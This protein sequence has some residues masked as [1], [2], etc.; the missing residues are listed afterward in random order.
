MKTFLFFTLL[1]FSFSL[2]ASHIVGGDI[3]YDYLGGNNYR[4]YITIYRDCASTGAAF[5]DPLPLAVYTNGSSSPI[6]QISVPFPG[7]VILPVTFNNPCGTAPGGV[8]IEKAV[9]IAVISLPPIQGGYTITYQRCCRGPAISNLSSPDNTGLTLTTNVPGSETGATQNSSPRF[10]N[11]PPLLLCNNDELIFDHSATDPDGDQLVYSLVI[12]FSGADAVTP[13][14]IPAPPPPYFPVTWAT[15]YTTTTPL[16]ASSPISINSSTGLLTATPNA[17]GLFVVGIRVQEYRNGVLIGQTIRDFLFRV[18]NCNITLSAQLPIQEDLASFVSYCQGLTVNFENNSYGGTVY[19][20][21]FGVNGIST[22]VSSTF[23]PSY[24]YPAPG[25]YQATLVVNPGEPCTDTARMTVTVNNEFS[26]SFTTQDSVCIVGNSLDFVSQTVGGAASSYAWD[27]GPNA[28]TSSAST[29]NVNN[30]SFNTSGFIPI[31]L[32]A[33]NSSCTATFTDSIYIFSEPT[34]SIILP[35]GYEC[36]GLTVS[37]GNNSSNAAIYQWDFGVTNSTM[38]TSSSVLPTYTF[39]AGGTYNVTLIGSSNGVCVD[40]TEE[41]ITVNELLTISFTHND[42]I[43]ITDNSFWFDGTMTGP[44]FTQYEWD[45]GPSASIQTSP[46]LDVNN[47]VFDSPGDHTIT[48]TAW[49]DNCYETAT[50]SIFI[51]R[52]PT[53]DFVDVPGLRC[54]PATV[55]FQNLSQAD[56]PLYYTWTFGDGDSSFSANPVHVYDA[57]GSYSVGL[58]VYTTEGCI[59]T[60]YLLKQDYITIHPSPVSKFSIDPAITDICNA[61]ITFTDQSQGATEFFYW[62]DD[63]TSFTTEQFPV[64]NYQSSGTLWPYQIATNE[65]GCKDTS[66]QKLIVEPF[67]IYLPNTFTP[68]G[69]EFNN[70][71]NGLFGLEVFGWELNIYNKWGQL[72]YQTTDPA[73]GWDGSY[74][75]RLMQEG[76]YTYVL[77]YIS[78]DQPEYWQILTGHVNLLR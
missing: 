18:L 51:Y 72:L 67:S 69:N 7:S 25:T 21:D 76:T 30:V 31:T 14:P 36:D 9:Y 15:G 26:V 10:T 55:Q 64:H 61:A 43:C 22:D 49:F 44:S 47:V 68:D 57:V 1:I 54:V 3:Y 34:A 40:T 39:P 53:I 58:E 33:E 16:G 5:D 38:D 41:Q 8:C 11:Y 24:T 4:F 52:V 59:D 35:V 17:L 32:E 46:D 70:E 27:F 28:S 56:S 74:Q 45:F 48:L 66:F 75:D 29:Q 37:F 2:R 50:S 20:W 19:Q 73:Y 13:A 77:K 42:S 71:F 60:L 23:E 65:F 62:F 63:S 78:C 6:Q 12:P